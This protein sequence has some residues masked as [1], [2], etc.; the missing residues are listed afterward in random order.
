MS[1]SKPALAVARLLTGVALAALASGCIKRDAPRMAA[2][3]PA[4]ENMG[5]ERVPVSAREDVARRWAA[6][7]AA[8]PKDP[9]AALNYARSLKAQGLNEQALD[10]LKRAYEATRDPEIA[11]ELGRLAMEK[12]DLV[13]AAPALEAA[14]AAS[15]GD[16]R[17]LSAQG[18]LFARKGQHKKA[19]DRFIA[20]LENNP[21]S[22]SIINNLALSYAMDGKKR[23]AEQ[24]LTTALAK[25]GSD[26]MRQNL[27]QVMRNPSE[28]PNQEIAAAPIAPDA[29]VANVAAPQPPNVPQPAPQPQA[30]LAQAALPIAAPEPAKAAPAQALR[31]RFD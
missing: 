6:A 17:L 3:D 5:A 26:R 1:A 15:P 23:E 2:A 11:S 18:A 27:V 24:L 10:V 28:G 20:A 16:W 14:L 9:K 19:Q 29:I 7:Y 30:V 25:G 12:G 22:P 21:G 4:A 8:N 13:A 31:T